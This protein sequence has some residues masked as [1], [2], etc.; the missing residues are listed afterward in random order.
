MLADVILEWSDGG[1]FCPSFSRSGGME[2]SEKVFW[3]GRGKWSSLL[4][5][6]SFSKSGN[7]PWLLP[8]IVTTLFV[9]VTRQDNISGTCMGLLRECHI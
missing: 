4:K 7:Y 9:R 2:W 6:R 5:F 1:I 8:V 3:E